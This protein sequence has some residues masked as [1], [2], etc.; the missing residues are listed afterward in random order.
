MPQFARVGSGA[1]VSVRTAVWVPGAT[2]FAALTPSGRAGAR[3][4]GAAGGRSPLRGH[5]ARSARCVSARC[6]C[7][8]RERTAR[9]NSYASRAPLTPLNLI[10]APHETSGMAQERRTGHAAQMLRT[11]AALTPSGQCASTAGE[12]RGTPGPSRRAD[13]TSKPAAGACTGRCAPGAPPPRCT[14]RS[15]HLR[16]AHPPPAAPSARRTPARRTLR[17]LRGHRARSARSTKRTRRTADR[18]THA[19]RPPDHPPGT[20]LP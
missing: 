16:S 15:A 13:Y 3:L 4:G 9:D 7:A 1:A 20:N 11:W 6:T 19:S 17:P 8:W 5:R 18:T 12:A 10:S 14:L 2:W